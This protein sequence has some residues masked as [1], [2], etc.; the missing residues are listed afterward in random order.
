MF[1]LLS[2]IFACKNVGG[3]TK[4]PETSFFPVSV[5]DFASFTVILG[6]S[7]AREADKIGLNQKYLSFDFQA[8]REMGFHMIFLRPSQLP[9]QKP[10]I[11]TMNAE[12]IRFEKSFQAYFA[13]AAQFSSRTGIYNGRGKKAFIEANLRAP[14]NDRDV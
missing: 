6:H 8:N 12:I 7:L 3:V 9:K 1:S 2:A 11:K 10:P 13:V 5:L 4:I 14:E